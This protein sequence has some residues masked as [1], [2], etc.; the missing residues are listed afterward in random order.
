M[1]SNEQHDQLRILLYD[2]IGRLDTFIATANMAEITDADSVQFVQE[3][4]G[5]LTE[6]IEGADN[7]P[8]RQGLDNIVHRLG[9]PLSVIVGFSELWSGADGLSMDQLDTLKAITRDG[10]RLSGMIDSVY[11]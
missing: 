4:A 11:G 9:S 2:L 6:I 3:S 8:V 5:R 7:E 10:M 1:A